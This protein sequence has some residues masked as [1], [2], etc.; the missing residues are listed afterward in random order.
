MPIGSLSP[1]AI[2]CPG[3]FVDRIVKC[4]E[5]KEFDILATAPPPSA[6]GA[7]DPEIEQCT[8]RKIA[9]R[10]AQEICDGF[11]VN[12]GVG[13]PTLVTEYLRPDIKIW[14]HSE[15]GILGMGPFPP[16]EERADPSVLVFI[17]SDDLLKNFRDITN[18]G[19]E[20]VTLLPGASVFGKEECSWFGTFA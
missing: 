10:A 16:S 12:L 17:S 1:N 14:L 18:A 6:D 11:Y 3:I 15:N 2:H 8:R 13:I 5:S 19:K 9:R 7:V 4:K 20:T